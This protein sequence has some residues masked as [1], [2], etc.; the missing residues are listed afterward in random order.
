[1]S[2]YVL[3]HLFCS[4]CENGRKS[5]GNQRTF[6]G[7]GTSRSYNIQ[8]IQRFMVTPHHTYEI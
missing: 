1:M 4:V 6:Y 7:D 8:V 3:E 5:D 2:H